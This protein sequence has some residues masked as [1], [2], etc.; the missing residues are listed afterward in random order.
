MNKCFRP[1]LHQAYL[2]VTSFYNQYLKA[3]YLIILSF[4]PAVDKGQP[5]GGKAVFLPFVM[6]EVPPVPEVFIFS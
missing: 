5:S 3:R 1:N 4:G 6:I 2:L